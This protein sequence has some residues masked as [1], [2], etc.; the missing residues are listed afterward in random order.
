MISFGIQS[1]FTN[2]SLDETID[3]CTGM[4]F[5]KRKK[6]KGMFTRYFKQVLILCV[7]WLCFLFNHVYYK[8]TDG[9]AMASPLG[10]TLADLFLVHHELKWLESCPTQFRL[11]FYCRYFDNTYVWAQRSCKE[12][13]KIYEFT[14]S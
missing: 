12:V 7:K 5:K 11:K 2:I 1:M 10:P 6:V 9:L 8:Q 14:S 3:I 4:V 13:R